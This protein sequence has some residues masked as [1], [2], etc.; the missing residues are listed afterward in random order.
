[1]AWVEGAGETAPVLASKFATAGADL[2]EISGN[3]VPSGACFTAE[4][5][6]DTPHGAV[7]IPQ[8]AVGDRVETIGDG[9][10]EYTTAVDPSTWRLVRLQMPNPD[11]SDDH[12]DIEILRPQD[13]VGT[14]RGAPGAWIPFSLA[15]MGINGVAQVLDVGPVRHLEEGRGRVVL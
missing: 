4:T 7:P 14:V 15:E 13:W 9:D 6:V 11:G 2:G 1:N 8:L 12:L 5:T 10:D 3:I